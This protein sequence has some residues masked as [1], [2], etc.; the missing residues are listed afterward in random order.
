[1]NNVRDLSFNGLEVRNTGD[2]SFESGFLL[3]EVL[4]TVSFARCAL[5]DNAGS[6][7]LIEQRFNK[8]RVTIDGG[9]LSATNRLSAAPNLLDLRIAGFGTLALDLHAVDLTDNAGGALVASTT[10]QSHLAVTL[11]DSSLQHVGGAVFSAIAAKE[12]ALLV[13]IHGTK[14]LILTALD[15]ALIEV[16]TTDTATACADLAGNTFITTGGPVPAIRLAASP[17][18]T[19]HIA[20]VR[21][22]G[23]LGAAN[24][25][26]PVTLDGSPR[27]VEWGGPCR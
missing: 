6:Q 27:G 18:A 23:A 24:G 17:T 10:E 1:M 11:R 3:Q 4:G 8:G 22:R 16:R 5:A 12:S 2:E 19:L 14:A 7:L 21:D 26:V 20:G 25:G 13:S 15:H 9:R